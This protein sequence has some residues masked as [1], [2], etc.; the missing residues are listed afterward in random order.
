LEPLPVPDE[1]L[2]W[3]G[4]PRDPYQGDPLFTF[5]YDQGFEFIDAIREQR[6]CTP[7]FLDG[8][9]VQAVID[10]ALVSAKEKRWIDMPQ[11]Y[12]QLWKETAN[13]SS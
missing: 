5:R 13:K 8:I 12:T 7:S 9:R 11:S 1:F 3:P 4:S 10:S 2:K 6:P